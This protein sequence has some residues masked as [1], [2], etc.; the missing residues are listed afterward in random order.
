MVAAMVAAMVAVLVAVVA[1][2]AAMVA[3]IGG[4]ISDFVARATWWVQW[5]QLAICYRKLASDWRIGSGGL[6]CSPAIR[7]TC[8]ATP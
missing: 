5:Q 4:S 3:A 1:M 8:S 6:R 2:V 7:A